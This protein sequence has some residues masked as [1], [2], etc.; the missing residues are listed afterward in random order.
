MTDDE[1]AA[2]GSTTRLREL[3]D[4]LNDDDW[5]NIEP[6]LLEFARKVASA[7]RERCAAIAQ[8]GGAPRSEEFGDWADV[9]EAIRT[10]LTPNLVL[11][12]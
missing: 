7:E 6:A 1:I 8:Q 5:N 11:E 9:E 10:G 4:L 2:I 12:P 3:P